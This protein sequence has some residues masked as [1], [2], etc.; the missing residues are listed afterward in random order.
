MDRCVECRNKRFKL[1]TMP[2]R[3]EISGVVFSGELAARQCVKCG[4][5]YARA[6]EL[7]RFE[8]AVAERLSS[9]GIRTGDAFKFMRKTLGLRA[10]DLAELLDVTAETVSRWETGEPEA[11]AFAL[12]GGMVAERMRGQ[13]ETVARLRAL[14]SRRKRPTRV[15]VRAA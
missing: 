1:S 12:L 4:Q 6:D 9:L 10:I 2:D 15:R 3:V 8:L 5:Q 13:E 14:K 7:G 11:R